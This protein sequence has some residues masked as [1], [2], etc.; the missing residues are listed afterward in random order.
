MCD[1]PFAIA[2]FVLL[3]VLILTAFSVI[4]INVVQFWYI[5]TLIIVANNL[6]ANPN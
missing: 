3:C 1:A 5:D 2:N 4:L 6:P